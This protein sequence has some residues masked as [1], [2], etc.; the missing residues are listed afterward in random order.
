MN[1]S[2]DIFP[3]W[4]KKKKHKWEVEERVDLRIR[5]PMIAHDS[6]GMRV[7]FD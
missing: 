4:Q 7:K 2:D 3:G 1:E 5:Q 6:W